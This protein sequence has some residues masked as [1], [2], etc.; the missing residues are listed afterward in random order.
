MRNLIFNFSEDSSVLHCCCL[1]LP[2]TIV[3]Q[4][5]TI[6]DKLTPKNQF[7][8]LNSFYFYQ[9][10]LAII[11]STTTKIITQIE[12]VDCKREDFRFQLL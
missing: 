9:T 4:D 2:L 1:I 3:I 11:L 5:A 10:M 12:N 8:S 6:N 7:C